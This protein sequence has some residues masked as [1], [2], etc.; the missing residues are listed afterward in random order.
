MRHHTGLIKRKTRDDLR[1]IGAVC[2]RRRGVFSVKMRKSG[3]RYC[4]KPTTKHRLWRRQCGAVARVVDARRINLRSMFWC[5]R[6]WNIKAFNH[7]A[8]FI[9]HSD[10]IS[11]AHHVVW[12]NGLRIH[13]DLNAV[14]TERAQFPAM[15]LS[16]ARW[17]R[18]GWALRNRGRRVGGHLL[19]LGGRSFH[20]RGKLIRWRCGCTGSTRL[21]GRPRNRR[22]ACCFGA[23]V[24]H[25]RLSRLLGAC[26]TGE[27]EGD[28]AR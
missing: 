23:F 13:E 11:L 3:R 16:I 8:L 17:A 6:I 21:T 22:C 1:Y 4:F 14:T 15:R 20:G 26:A 25:R 10:V 7:R 18:I 24:G 9:D 27:C 28:A 19:R 5:P 12:R 2:T